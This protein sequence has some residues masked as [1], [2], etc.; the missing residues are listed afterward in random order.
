MNLQRQQAWVIWIPE[1]L[2]GVLASWWSL[3][4]AGG[5]AVSYGARETNPVALAVAWLLVPTS[6]AGGHV[7][8]GMKLRRLRRTEERARGLLWLREA[9]CWEGAVVGTHITAL[10][11]ALLLAPRGE[12][13]SLP[14]GLW[15]DALMLVLAPLLAGGV[16]L[17][18][19]VALKL[20][21]WR[22][23]GGGQGPRQEAT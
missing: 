15:F 8:I 7:W 20:R 17:Q 5:I 1:I 9:V 19:W 18:V 23:E 3:S 14:S 10:P 11:V 21:K 13:I 22:R 4:V 6:L 16:G 12:L 2:C